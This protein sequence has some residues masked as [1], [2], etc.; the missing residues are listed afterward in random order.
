MVKEAN[1]SPISEKKKIDT[2]YKTYKSQISKETVDISKNNK[3]DTLNTIDRSRST[4]RTNLSNKI[5][6]IIKN[7][8]NRYSRVQ[9]KCFY[10]SVKGE[11]LA[12][13]APDNNTIPCKNKERKLQTL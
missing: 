12:S 3:T 1:T 11:I 9:F 10:F 6:R 2:V 8:R 5:A 13:V 4:P 7:L